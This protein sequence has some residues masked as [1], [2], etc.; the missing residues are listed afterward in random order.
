M[1]LADIGLLLFGL[2]LLGPFINF[3]IYSFAYFPRPISPWQTR[4]AEILV[5]SSAAKLPVAGWLFRREEIFHFGR[6]FWLRPMLIE[7]AT[8][9]VLVFAYRYCI[10]GA[11]MPV[12][13]LPVGPSTLLHQ[14]IAFALLFTLMAVAT[15]I[16]FDERTI[17]DFVT[18][19][20]TLLGLVGA[21]VFPDW[22]FHE[23][24]FPVFPAVLGNLVPIQANSP[25]PW[26]PIWYGNVGFLLAL[27]FWSGWCFGMADRRWIGRRGMKKAFAY[28]FEVLRR[29]PSTKMLVGL[30]IVGLI[31]LCAAYWK[32]S[33]EQWESLLSALFGMGMGG[34]LVWGFRIAASVAMRQEALGFGDVTLMAMIGSFFGWQIVWLAFFLAPFFGMLFVLIVWAITRDNSLPFGPYLCAATVY[35]MLNWNSLWDSFSVFFFPPQYMLILLPVLLLTLGALLWMIQAFK[36]M[37]GSATAKQPAQ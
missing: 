15:F 17:P 6:M 3:A 36:K 16:D 10:A 21:I 26:N 25:D 2:L 30:W 28:F 5:R 11:Y 9:L 7:L 33:P 20:G 14:F 12:G 31:C 13:L 1:G 23:V 18:I 34:G 27:F 22:R 24:T 32:I 19:P 35:C 4:P 29:S 37:I 8:P